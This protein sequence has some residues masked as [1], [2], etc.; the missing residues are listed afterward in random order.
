MKTAVYLLSRTYGDSRSSGAEVL[1][2]PFTGFT[3]NQP[4]G[5]RRTEYLRE[6]GSQE[7]SKVR[8][9]SIA[10]HEHLQEKPRQRFKRKEEQSE[11]C[12][13]GPDGTHCA[14]KHIRVGAVGKKPSG[15]RRT[16][17]DGPF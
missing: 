8:R 9:Q 15:S 7:V 17:D 16:G 14:P 5:S 3:L 13:N 11:T 12:Q 6:K 4:A 1:T 2:V 10:S